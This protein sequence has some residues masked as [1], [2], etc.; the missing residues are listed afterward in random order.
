M[1]IYMKNI[2][3]I[4]IAVIVILTAILGIMYMVDIDRMNNNRHVLFS[5]W[6]KK[7][8]IPV[9]E[10]NNEVEISKEE[11]KKELPKEYNLEQ[12]VKD[13]CF[14]ITYNKIYNKDKLDRF[15][16]NTDINSKN[17][18][19]D[20]I[21]IVQ[22]T[23]EG[24]PIVIELSYKIKPETYE[25]EGKQVNKTTYILK[26]DTTRDKFAA[27]DGGKVTIDD[28]IPGEFFGIVEEKNGKVVDIKLSLYAIIDYVDA[29]VKQYKEINV[30]SYSSD[31]KVINDSNSIEQAK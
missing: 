21:T 8:T 7:Y 4:V 16:K 6:G 30:C 3:K 29:S 14:V 26:T 13:G 2:L 22:Y 11:P 15:I 12:A 31:A 20:S 9:E 18:I 19:E 5:T 28:D 17:R 10:Q 23:I 1:V 25:L 27:Q 24:D